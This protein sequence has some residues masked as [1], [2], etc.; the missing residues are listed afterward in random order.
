MVM[1][2]IAF[3][4]TV[5]YPLNIITCVDCTMLLKLLKVGG[6]QILQGHTKVAGH[7]RIGM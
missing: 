5:F 4:S 3:T 2:D 7:L 6:N 1:P